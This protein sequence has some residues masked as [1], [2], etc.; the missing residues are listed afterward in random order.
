VKIVSPQTAVQSITS[1]NGVFVHSAAAVPRSLIQALS[2]KHKELKGVRIYSIH[3][4]GEAPYANLDYID[5]FI[6]HP[7]FVGNNIRQVL[8]KKM[9]SYIPTFLSEVPTLFRTGR[10]PIDVALI[11]VSPP[12][13]HGY[14]SLGP[15]VDISLAAIQSAKIVIAEINACMPRT[16]GDGFISLKDI[17]LAVENNICLP[18]VIRPFLSEEEILVGKNIADLIENG[19]TLQ[20][21]IGAI[22]NAVMQFLHNH[23]PELLVTK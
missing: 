8:E 20:M 14:C 7:F 21:G 19:A 22:P 16:H 18:E 4:E 12:D 1:F 9:G 3:T 23:N 13:K 2:L 11:S 5:S 17:D 15:S 6:L 10:I